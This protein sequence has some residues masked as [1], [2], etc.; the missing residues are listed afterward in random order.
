MKNIKREKMGALNKS[1]SRE[2]YSYLEGFYVGSIV[3]QLERDFFVMVSEKRALYIIVVVCPD[4][5]PL[6]Y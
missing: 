3:R 2:L 5:T 4:A 1:F 6:L